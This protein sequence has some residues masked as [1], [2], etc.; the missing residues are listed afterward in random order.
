M[1]IK[2]VI[3][4]LSL[5]AASGL[6][7]LPAL[8]QYFPAPL[9]VGSSPTFSKL[10]VTG[11]VVFPRRA[12]ADVDSTQTINDYTIA[13]TSITAPRT[14]NL[15]TTGMVAGQRFEIKDEAGAAGTFNL[16]TA[17]VLIDGVN[18][19]ITTNFGA[20]Q[21]YYNGSTFSSE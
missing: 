2:R 8:A 7:T 15:I 6:I 19:S 1:K 12:I 13:Y 18:K 16:T 9:G 5:I 17:G 14:I 21:F 11:G 4:S 3:A 10:T 20:L